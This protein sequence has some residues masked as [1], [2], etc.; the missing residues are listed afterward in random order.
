MKMEPKTGAAT[1]GK[2]VFGWSLSLPV[3]IL[4][5]LRWSFVWL[6]SLFD[7]RRAQG[8]YESFNRT[9]IGAGEI[10]RLLPLI[11]PSLGI[12]FNDHAAPV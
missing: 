8:I 6:I 2:L 7:L 11:K 5:G 10:S 1:S 12:S 3:L 4:R 9:E